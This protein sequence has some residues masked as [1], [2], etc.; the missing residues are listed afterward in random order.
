MIFSVKMF[1]L[2]NSARKSINMIVDGW[3]FDQGE[4]FASSVDRWNLLAN[5]DT[6][7][8]VSFFVFAI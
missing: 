7:S 2:A 5:F 8:E 1:D 4:L 6:P 3:F